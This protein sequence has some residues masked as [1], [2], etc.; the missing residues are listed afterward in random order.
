MRTSGSA[1]VAVV[2]GLALAGCKGQELEARSRF[3]ED[4]VKLDA[5]AAWGGEAVVVESSG[6]TT[7]GGLSLSVEDDDH[8]RSTAR[9]LAVADTT[10]KASADAAIDEVKKTA[11]AISTAA[12]VTTVRCGTVA[13]FASVAAGDAGCDALDVTFPGGATDR[14]LTV[15]ARSAK[16]LVAGSFAGATLKNLELHGSNGRIE[17]TVPATKDATILVVAET[18]DEVVLRLP[19][20]FAAD[21]MVLEAPAGAVDTSAFPDVQTGK[22]RGE[23]GR[24]AKSITVRAG[25]IVVTRA[26]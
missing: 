2:L 16:G 5:P 15:T 22:G 26:E 10:D 3:V 23:A 6:V 14:P 20:D 4:G 17:L 12:G 25:R 1:P 8:V 9:M 19:V 24:G 18:G 11:Y 13:R 21:A 7:T